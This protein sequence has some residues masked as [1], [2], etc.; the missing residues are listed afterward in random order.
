MLFRLRKRF[1]GVG[2]WLDDVGLITGLSIPFVSPFGVP[3]RVPLVSDIEFWDG[4][5]L[6]VGAPLVV[7]VVAGGGTAP[8]GGGGGGVGSRS[9]GGMS[10]PSVREPKPPTERAGSSN[11]VGAAARLFVLIMNRE[12]VLAVVLEVESGLV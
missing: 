3:G 8:G 6:C 11:F 10:V 5:L 9:G 7:G 12:P 2:G 1:K 4:F